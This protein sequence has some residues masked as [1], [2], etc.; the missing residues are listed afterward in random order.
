VRQLAKNEL[1][2]QALLLYAFREEW[3]P[4]LRPI[5]TLTHRY[6]LYFGPYQEQTALLYLNSHR[7]DKCDWSA[8]LAQSALLCPQEAPRRIQLQFACLTLL[9]HFLDRNLAVS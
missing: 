5:T 8:R 7:S 3:Q 9:Q 2:F 6:Q 4:L 1:P